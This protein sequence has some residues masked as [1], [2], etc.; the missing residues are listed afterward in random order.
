ME[1]LAFY[2]WSPL[3]LRR[4][5]RRS[6]LWAR[7]ARSSPRADASWTSRSACGRSAG[8]SRSIPAAWRSAN[9]IRHGP[10]GPGPGARSAPGKTPATIRR[11]I[12]SFEHPDTSAALLIDNN[13]SLTAAFVPSLHG[14]ACCI[15]QPREHWSS[16]HAS[17]YGRDGHLPMTY[18]WLTSPSRPPPPSPSMSA[19]PSRSCRTYLAPTLIRSSRTPHTPFAGS[20]GALHHDRPPS[21]PDA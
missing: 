14:L 15:R 3:S 12:V 5:R 1:G 7:S 2:P 20:R 21:N 18:A 10:P 4:R 16:G 17:P 9:G 19:M 13:S 8:S 11:L 6:A